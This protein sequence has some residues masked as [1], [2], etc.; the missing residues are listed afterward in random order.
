MLN[1]SKPACQIGSEMPCV[2]PFKYARLHSIVV[3]QCGTA[4]LSLPVGFKG[5]K[6][7]MK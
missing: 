2:H 7:Q 5:Q 3:P 6:G 4:C 1:S